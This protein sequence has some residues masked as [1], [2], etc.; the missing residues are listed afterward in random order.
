MADSDVTKIEDSAEKAYAAASEETAPAE[1]PAKDETAET[2]E[3]SA[4]PTRARK[5]DVAA[6]E[7]V[8]ELPVVEA[9]SAGLEPK[10]APTKVIKATKPTI[11]R[12]A[13]KPVPAAP[14]RAAK[15]APIKARKA[16]VQKIKTAPKAAPKTVKASTA[17]ASTVAAPTIPFIAK[18]KEIPMDVTTSIKDA[19]NG[20]QDKA[21][22][23]FTKTSAAASEYTEFAK[24]NVEAFVESGKILASGLQEL[25]NKFVADSKSAYETATADVKALSG[26]KSPTDFFKFQTDLLRRNIDTAIAYTSKNGEAVLKLTNDVIAPISGRVSLAVEKVKKAA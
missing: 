1:L 16:S 3:F 13:A 2:V 19:V 24:G 25:G 8:A 22:E 5:A 21:K 7:P 18:I 15:S 9:V 26:I 17:K 4:K 14:A 6:A 11:K 20:A 23:A 10:P 12:A